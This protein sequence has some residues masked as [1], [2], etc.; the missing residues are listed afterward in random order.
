MRG[1]VVP[2]AQGAGA[3]GGKGFG[4]WSFDFRLN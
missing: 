1:K 3:F 4:F 2:V